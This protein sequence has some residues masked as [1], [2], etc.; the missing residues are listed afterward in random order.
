MTGLNR[1]IRSASSL[2]EFL[3]LPR[4][5]CFEGEHFAF[6]HLGTVSGWRVWGAPDV[7]D[8]RAL[9][10]CIDT[11]YRPGS[12]RYFSL[13]DLRG[14]ES[15]SEPGF[16][17]LRDY[18]DQLRGKM[19]RLL[20]RQA[21]VKP[22]GLV[23]AMVAGFYVQLPPRHPVRVF[24][25]VAKAARW[26]NPSDRKALRALVSALRA[27][28]RGAGGT[29]ATLREWLRVN[30]H[31]AR[32]DDAA[33]AL[34][35]SKR[36]LQRRLREKGTA[37]RAQLRQVRVELA[38]RLLRDTDWKLLAIAQD[39]G[40]DSSQQFATMFRASTGLSPSE[41]RGRYRA[42]LSP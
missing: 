25:S 7:E 29:M 21:V 2:K 4:G 37:F 1:M 3:E 14:L 35:L 26:L 36:T 12:P 19:A 17:V 27:P 31:H 33:R 40:F 13:V 28:P 42:Q 32:P 39:V 41:F 5:A 15:V 8:G 22:A 11:L 9:V 10:Q 24:D 23:G 18:V 38:E 6:W 34:G 30:R 16:E 20:V